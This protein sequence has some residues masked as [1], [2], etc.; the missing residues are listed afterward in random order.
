MLV[1]QGLHTH[2][3]EQCQQLGNVIDA[4]TENGR[5][6]SHVVMLC[7][8]GDRDPSTICKTTQNLSEPSVFA[9][10]QASGILLK[11]VGAHPPLAHGKCS[12]PRRT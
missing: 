12:L 3:V 6:F 2:A 10:R 11:K 8:L 1:Q 4:F 5:C 9:H 7:L